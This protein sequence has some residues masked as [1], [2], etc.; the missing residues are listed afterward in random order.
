MGQTTSIEAAQGAPGL[1]DRKKARRREEILEAA[2][3]LFASQGVDAT[4]MAD[5]AEAVG[6]SQPTV[7]NYFGNKGG[8]LIALIHEGAARE[9]QHSKIMVPRTD[10]DFATLLVTI[11]S[12][13]A[14]GT[15]R[16][17]SKR[18]WRYAEADTIRYPTTE[19]AQSYQI[20]NTELM[21]VLRQVLS[22]YDLTLHDGN[23]A[24]VDHL[25]QILYDIWGGAYFDLIRSE[26]MTIA[27]H[28]IALTQR[29]EPLCRMIFAP[30]FLAEPTLKTTIGD[31]A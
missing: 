19:L 6:V 22:S 13:F 26:D 28:R 12:E 27:D 7:F 11:F 8:I 17:A 5:I 16:I 10:L 30:D 18:I 21:S 20:V 31:P 1:R 23:P 29:L 14:E 15:L 9:R 3:G 2:Q 25:V 24:D 4:T